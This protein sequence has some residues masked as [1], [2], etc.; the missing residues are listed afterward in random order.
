M[1][2]CVFW[3]PN[4]KVSVTLWR[5]CGSKI[6]GSILY[7]SGHDLSLG[8]RFVVRVEHKLGSGQVRVRVRDEVMARDSV[9]LEKSSRSCRN[10]PTKIAQM[11]PRHS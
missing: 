8:I 11:C 10:D 4:L 3:G 1:C 6:L 2:V 9:W 7:L 5:L